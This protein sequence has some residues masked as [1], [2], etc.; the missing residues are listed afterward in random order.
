MADPY[1]AEIRMFA[2]NFAPFGWATCDGQIMA[3]SQN[4]ALFSLLGT[5]FGGNGTSNF[6]LPNLQGSAPM[7]QGNGIGLTPRVVGE[8]GGVPNVTL[9]SNEMAAHT[10]LFQGIGVVG[11]QTTPAGN[12]LAQQRTL[13]PYATPAAGQ[14][15]SS[16][17]IG[18][19]GG[20]LP[21]NN[22]QPYL[23]VTF[24]IALQGI[25]PARG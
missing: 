2:G 13:N 4:T 17:A 3:I 9:L 1:L 10:H 22:M 6:G 8:T 16:N 14:A 20:N 15:M 7:G 18:P 19:A 24:I 12:L 25:F 21:H 23:A 11:N 5:Q